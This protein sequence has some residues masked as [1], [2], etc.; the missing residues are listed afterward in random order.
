MINVAVYFGTDITVKFTG[1]VRKAL[2]I[3][4]GLSVS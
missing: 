4:E 1:I 2:Y 3:S